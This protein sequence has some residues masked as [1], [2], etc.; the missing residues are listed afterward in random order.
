MTEQNVVDADAQRKA[1][2]QTTALSYLNKLFNASVE[3]T[4]ETTFDQL[5]M[6]SLDVLEYMMILEDNH[7]ILPLDDSHLHDFKTVGDVL[8]AVQFKP[9]PN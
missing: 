7:D 1:E 2:L 6:D 9:I 8:N 5:S 4:L 3:V